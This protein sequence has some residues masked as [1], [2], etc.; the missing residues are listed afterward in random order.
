MLSLCCQWSVFFHDEDLWMSCWR[1]C[2]LWLS[3]M[4][5]FGCTCTRG[6]V[7]SVGV[8]C[9]GCVVLVLCCVTVGVVGFVLQVGV[10]CM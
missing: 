3:V 6:V 4:M 9:C 2:R 8:K 1:T 7:V 5:C 10:V